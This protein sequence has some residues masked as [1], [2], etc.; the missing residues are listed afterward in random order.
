MVLI[1]G[2]SHSPRRTARIWSSSHA[3]ASRLVLNV[4]LC[5]LPEASRY[6]PCQLIPVF[7][8]RFVGIVRVPTIKNFSWLS[9]I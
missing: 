6:R 2:S 8:T 3:F 5:S 4:L 1:C 9:H 7:R